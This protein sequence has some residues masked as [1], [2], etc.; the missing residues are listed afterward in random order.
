M[1]FV[2]I[3]MLHWT[4]TGLIS[5]LLFLANWIILYL[6]ALVMFRI[7][8]LHQHAR[9][10]KKS[11]KLAKFE[12]L[13]NDEDDMEYTML[14]DQDRKAVAPFQNYKTQP[15]PSKVGSLDD[16]PSSQTSVLS[17]ASRGSA[18]GA[19]GN[20]EEVR[21]ITCSPQEQSTT[22]SQSR[23]IPMS[24]R[25]RSSGTSREHASLLKTGSL[26]EVPR[27]QQHL[28]KEVSVSLNNASSERLIQSADSKAQN[29]KEQEKELSNEPL[30]LPQ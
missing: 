14:D 16:T 3:Q 27:G 7:K 30:F 21:D 5:L 22:R 17:S 18:A 20:F 8:K 13:L 25:K 10:E 6:S 12:K 26:K 19:S 15:M 2:C 11:E 9:S 24:T 28:M 29:S 4:T 1:A 23:K